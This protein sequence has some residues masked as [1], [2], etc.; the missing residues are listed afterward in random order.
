MSILLSHDLSRRVQGKSGNLECH[1]WLHHERDQ[2]GREGQVWLEGK[3]GR[4]KRDERE[5][6]RR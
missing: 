6:K 1:S 4:E 2:R 5:M 3:R